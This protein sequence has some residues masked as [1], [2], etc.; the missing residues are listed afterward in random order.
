MLTMSWFHGIEAISINRVAYD[1]CVYLMGILKLMQK[2]K[3][4]TM[5]MLLY[6]F[7]QNESIKPSWHVP[8]LS[9]NLRQT[10]V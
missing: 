1:M 5:H 4:T 8:V 7:N 6:Q 9:V 10:C 2:K 3:Q